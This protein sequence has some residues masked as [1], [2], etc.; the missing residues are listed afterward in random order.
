MKTKMTIHKIAQI[1]RCIRGEFGRGN[2]TRVN[3]A[4]TR[5]M[6]CADTDSAQSIAHHGAVEAWQRIVELGLAT[7]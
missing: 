5:G 3:N 4:E 7:S 1:E 2:L 6:T